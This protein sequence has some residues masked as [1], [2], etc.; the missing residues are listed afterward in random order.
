LEWITEIFIKF[1][2]DHNDFLSAEE[3]HNFAT[4]FD[5][6]KITVEAANNTVSGYDIDGDGQLDLDEFTNIVIVM[7]YGHR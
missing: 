1:D 7:I 3:F 4:K 2:E 6:H 5:N